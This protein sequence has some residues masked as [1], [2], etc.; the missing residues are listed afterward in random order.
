MKWRNWEWNYGRKKK[1]E[2][3]AYKIS[4][5]T[6]CGSWKRWLAEEYV[7]A[8]LTQQCRTLKK[9]KGQTNDLNPKSCERKGY[10]QM[11]KRR[12]QCSFYYDSKQTLELIGW[13]SVLHPERDYYF[14]YLRYPYK[15]SYCRMY[16]NQ[17]FYFLNFKVKSI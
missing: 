1:E 6:P 16:P 14:N 5:K 11:L 9:T 7:E 8:E 2:E 3:E 12:E 4:Y 13:F 10:T 17:N 15:H